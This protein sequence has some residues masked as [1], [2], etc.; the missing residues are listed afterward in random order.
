MSREFFDSAEPQSLIKSALVLRYFWAWKTIMLPRLKRPQDRLAYL[1]LFSGPGRFEDGEP[2]TPLGVLQE[3]INDPQLC[4]RLVTIFNDADPAHVVNLQTEIDNLDGIRKLEI[5][6]RVTNFRIGTDAIEE[7]ESV[8]KSPTLFFIDPFGYKG[9]SIEM[10]G[11]AIRPWG[12]DCIFF[13]NYNRI[14]PGISNP[15]VASLMDQLFGKIRADELRSEIQGTSSAERKRLILAALIDGLRE[16]GGKY[17]LPFEFKKN[18]GERTSYYIV[19]VSK[20]SVAYHI[21][22]NVMASL[23]TDEGAVKN[24]EFVPIKSPQLKFSFAET[25]PYTIAA[26][27]QLLLEVCSGSTMKVADIYEEYTFDTPYTLKNVQTALLELEIER[28]VE[29]DKP[30]ERHIREG[31]VTL[32]KDRLV[33]FLAKE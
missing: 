24:F 1:D 12:C 29:V 9:L 7:I 26:L 8:S 2:S 33:T 27:K 28:R 31:L 17:V 21:M 4:K 5:P 16:V 22:K 10:I 18:S 15:M 32:G 11:K 25:R 19:F 3:A 6:P 30:P 20:S 14:S 13:F 23:S